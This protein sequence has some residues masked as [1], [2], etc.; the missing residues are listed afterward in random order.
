MHYHVISSFCLTSMAVW[1]SSCSGIAIVILFII[2]LSNILLYFIQFY[3]LNFI[4]KFKFSCLRLSMNFIQ[5][6]FHL[7]FYN[8]S[9]QLFIFIISLLLFVKLVSYNILIFVF[10]FSFSR[11][12]LWFSVY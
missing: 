6:E 8:F 2:E 12:I 1:Q 4:Y 3:S 11:Y 10:F 9:I 5:L 7:F